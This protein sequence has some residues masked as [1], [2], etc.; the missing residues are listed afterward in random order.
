MRITYTNR[1]LSPFEELVLSQAPISE[2][3]KMLDNV[4]NDKT[5]VKELAKDS[6]FCHIQASIKKMKACFRQRFVPFHGNFTLNVIPPT[7]LPQ[8][9]IVSLTTKIL[10]LRLTNRMKRITVI[11]F[12]LLYLVSTSGVAWSNFYCCGKIKETYIFHHHD[13]GKDCKGNKKASDCC[14]TK[15]FFFKVKDSHSPSVAKT[16]ATDFSLIAH[17]FPVF[18]FSFTENN[19]AFSFLNY[20]PPSIE[21]D[22]PV[23]IQSF[24]I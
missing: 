19:N 11:L 4:L 16:I 8:T 22:I 23:L 1:Q 14:D 6:F 3:Y 15:T 24:L 5:L 12:T 20:H 2:H 13:Y 18:I 21:R 17:H 7:I 10:S 9:F